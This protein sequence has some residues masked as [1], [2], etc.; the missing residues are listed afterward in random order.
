MPP[1]SDLACFL[2]D[3]TINWHKEG[4]VNPVSAILRFSYLCYIQVDVQTRLQVLQS[5][6]GHT[7]S[8]REHSHGMTS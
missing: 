5:Y 3:G 1:G 7:H 2:D 4:K 6:D 8:L